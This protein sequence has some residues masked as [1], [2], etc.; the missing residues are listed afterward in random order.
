MD[1]QG[2]KLPEKDGTQLEEL[3]GGA[4]HSRVGT[5]RTASGTAGISI[6]STGLILRL[7][8]STVMSKSKLSMSPIPRI[9]MLNDESRLL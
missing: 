6:L 4:R 3:D 1:G 8:R 7:P 5:Y 9:R 2:Q